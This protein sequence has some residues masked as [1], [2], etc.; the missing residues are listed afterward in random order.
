MSGGTFNY[1]QQVLDD[2]ALTLDDY[3]QDTSFNY[4]D[5]RTKQLLITTRDDLLRLSQ[6]LYKLDLF[7][8]GDSGEGAIHLSD[9]SMDK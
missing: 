9:N 5:A 2:I 3:V 6:V 1:T 7:L 4:E 8:A